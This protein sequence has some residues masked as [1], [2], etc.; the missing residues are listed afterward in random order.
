MLEI[1]GTCGSL[2]MDLKEEELKRLCACHQSREDSTRLVT[3]GG[4]TR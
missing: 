1:R 4:R 3:K 2:N